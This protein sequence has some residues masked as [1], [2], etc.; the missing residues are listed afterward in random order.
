MTYTYQMYSY[1]LRNNLQDLYTGVVLPNNLE[2]LPDWIAQITEDGHRILWKS[3]GLT[4]PNVITLLQTESITSSSGL[5]TF[6][7]AEYEI[8]V[9]DVEEQWIVYFME[10]EGI[11]SAFSIRVNEYYDTVLSTTDFIIQSYQHKV[12]V[13]E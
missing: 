12:I 6:I 3:M 11:F 9:D 10:E 5:Q 7:R 1:F 4:L 2:D 8:I 13:M